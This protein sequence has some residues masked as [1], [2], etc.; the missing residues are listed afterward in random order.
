LEC[1]LPEPLVTRLG[2]SRSYDRQKKY[3]RA[4]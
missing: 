3:D 4:G 1:T 2:D